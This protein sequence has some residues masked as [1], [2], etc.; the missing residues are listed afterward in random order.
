MPTIID[1]AKQSGFSKSTVSRV[2]NHDPNVNP[3]TREIIQNVINEMKYKNNELARS[4]LKGSVRI[5]LFIVGD[6]LNSFH[7]RMVKG[8][9]D[10]LSKAG[11]MVVISDS[12]FDSAK[13]LHFLNM[14]CENK[15]AGVIMM[16]GFETEELHNMIAQ[17][18]CPVV[19][20]NR[21]FEKMMLDTV[22]INNYES[23]YIAAEYLIQKGHRKIKHLTGFPG[24]STNREVICG[25]AQALA[26]AGITFF[27]EQVTRGD[28]T[29][30]CGYQYAKEIFKSKNE[31]TAVFVS[32]YM[33][34]A[35]FERGFT[36]C[37]GRIPE[38][39][40]LICQDAI[41]SIKLSPL[42]ITAVA[43]D[44]IST[45]VF[46]AETLLKRLSQKD[47]PI[48]IV[49]CPPTLFERESVIQNKI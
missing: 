17:M 39:I 27:N 21:Q 19:L 46:A 8:I 16:A 31:F 6:M 47:L 20:L 14:V 41:P 7:T 43:S 5:V 33:M 26:D 2:I 13:E 32:N 44:P 30:L 34:A 10:T 3:K 49:K 38:D 48:Q 42:D 37:G 24:S 22:T 12:E 36:E 25:F 28:L 45:G 11:Y 40:S 29:W 15:F 18:E 23:G 35:G 4:M 9:S 1:I